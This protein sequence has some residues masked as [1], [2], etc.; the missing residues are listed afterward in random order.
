MRTKG[1]HTC[2]KNGGR[3]H[4]EKESPFFAKHDPDKKKYQFLGSG[5]YF[6]D[7]NIE[8]AKVWGYSHCKNDYFV[9]EIDIELTEDTCLDLVG[10]RRHMMF[11]AA[12]MEKLRKEKGISKS[13]WT[14]SQCIEFL[15]RLSKDNIS[16]FPYK[17]IRAIDYN[18]D[19]KQKVAKFVK[20]KGNFTTLSPKMV[21]C[22]IEKKMLPLHTKRIIHE[23]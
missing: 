15:K 6:W 7:D 10:N 17:I 11:F 13:E 3:E 1:H 23:S 12:V 22:V 14:I 19:F 9:V 4:V 2:T 16:I 8:L 21:I 18:D 5:Y 20:D